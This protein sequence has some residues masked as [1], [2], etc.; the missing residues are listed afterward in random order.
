MFLASFD[1]I[2]A[3]YR[4]M[5]YRAA[6]S[7]VAGQKAAAAPSRHYR[8]AHADAG[9]LIAASIGRPF[10]KTASACAMHLHTRLSKEL[11][12]NT[13]STAPQKHQPFL[14]VI[15]SMR[16][17]GAMLRRATSSHFWLFDAAHTTYTSPFVGF[18]HFIES[19]G[20][21]MIIFIVGATAKFLGA[22]LITGRHARAFEIS[23]FAHDAA[24]DYYC[25]RAKPH[26]KA[27]KFYIV[28]LSYIILPLAGRS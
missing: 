15:H 16:Y 8:V 28:P 26:F 22:T 21:T 27:S 18:Q 25:R 14:A 2:F 7:R 1:S 13:A 10:H 6:S 24:D 17:F 4:T 5:A 3:L 11:P 19:R 12:Q 20:H 23:C 9:I